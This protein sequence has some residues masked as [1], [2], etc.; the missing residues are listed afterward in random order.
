MPSEKRSGSLLFVTQLPPPHHGQTGIAARMYEVFRQDA[1]LDVRYLWRGGARDA[2]DVGRRSLTKYFEL[3]TLILELGFFWLSRRR[4]DLAYLGLAPWAS[5]ALRDVL[6]IWLCRHI[7]GRVLVHVHGDGLSAL[8]QRPGAAGDL[9]RKGLTGSEILAVASKTAN[10]AEAAGIFSSVT[11]L[12]NTVPDP[13]DP[14]LESSRSLRVGCLCNLDDRKGVFEFIDVIQAL[15]QREIPV[16]AT[17]AG[18]STARLSLEAVRERVSDRGLS[19]RI[20]LLGHVGGKDKHDA[21]SRQDVFLYLSRHDLAPLSLLEA[22]AHGNAPV[23]IDVG[24]L[25]EI[26]GP[27]LECNVLPTSYSRDEVVARA[28]EIIGTYTNDPD[29]LARDKALAR[30]RYTDEYRPTAFRERVVDI[31]KDPGR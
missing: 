20:V 3:C 23:V 19:G 5:T 13:G 7:A 9:V 14:S 21:L 22:L 16:Q 11:L 4:F 30:K 6:L 31:V 15:T 29:L 27:E 10:E 2:Q 24:G 18:G 1:G 25:R 8:L 17:I 12:P 28:V 26:V